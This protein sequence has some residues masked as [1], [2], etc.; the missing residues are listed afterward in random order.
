MAKKALKG[1]KPTAGDDILNGSNKNDVINGKGGDDVITGGAGND[2][3]NGGAGNDVLR[4]GD[5]DDNLIGGTGNDR[6]LG[7]AGDDTIDATSG[8]DTVDGGA[9]DDIVKVKGNFADAVITAVSGGYK[10]VLGGQTTVIKNVEMVKFSDGIVDADDLIPVTQFVLTSSI[11]TVNGSVGNDTIKSDG[12][13]ISALDTIDGGNGR[14]SIVVTDQT[15]NG[16]TLNSDLANVS[17]VEDLSVTVGG[18]DVSAD[19]SGWVG[20]DTVSVNTRDAGWG[21]DVNLT[22]GGNV[23]SITVTGGDE[24]EI[25]DNGATQAL[26]SVTLNK[27]EDY[28]DIESEALKTLNIAASGDN[29]VS[30]WTDTKQALTATITGSKVVDIDANTATS[31]TASVDKSGQYLGIEADLATSVSVTGAG[32][33]TLN[34]DAAAATSVSFTAGDESTIVVT[35]ATAATTLTF[36]GA[37]SIAVAGTIATTVTAIDASANTGGVTTGALGDDVVFT[38]GAGKDSIVLGATN[39]A[40]DMGAG[41]DTVTLTAALGIG[42]S[43]KGGAGTDTLVLTDTVADGA[44]GSATFTTQVTGFENLKLSNALNGALDVSKLGTFG[45]IT[46]AAGGS[47]ALN[48]LGANST[49]H[50]LAGATATFGLAN[51]A[52]VSDAINVSVE[53]ITGSTS[54]LTLTGIETLN[55]K[56]DDTATVASG[57]YQN[58]VNVIDADLKTVV[59]SGDAGLDLNLLGAGAVTSV[60]TSGITK[61]AV[62]V[63]LGAVAPLTAPATSTITI[64]G[65]DTAT[66]VVGTAIVDPQVS[67]NVTTG[68]GDDLII[69]G[70]G[71]DTIKAGDGANTVNSGAGNDNITGGAGIDTVDGGAGNDTIS[72]LGG[73]DVLKGG[74]GNDS[75]DGGA[76]DDIIEGGLGQ[77][78]LTG[79]AGKDTFVFNAA[80]SAFNA[81]DTITDFASGTDKLQLAGVDLADFIF[82][83][84]VSGDL[85]VQAAVADGANVGDDMIR[86][87]FNSANNTLYVDSDSSG[88]IGAGDLVIKLNG[89]TSLSFDAAGPFADDFLFAI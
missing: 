23:T 30:V 69:G 33:L 19:V 53:G 48:G 57:M 31:V 22:T 55:L 3:L 5:G 62:S 14:D 37:G 6:L 87:V 12:F 51:S 61:G 58:V 77:D 65:G 38:G 27:L 13:G 8:N 43:V 85:S 54:T 76:G 46:L 18:G 82:A 81:F 68:K 71:N 78:A 75:I 49:V 17:N 34:V 40:N 45:D 86:A 9:G 42:G 60:D 24:V 47:G 28:A 21:N 4:G 79:G 63:T 44:A 67:L 66:T 50:L 16:I 39:K 26:A 88:T 11:D 15:T 2:T 25:S 20:L 10:I 52:G 56:S 36:A 35:D 80:D 7:G 29:N 1:N 84:N 70:A 59:A 32:K 74:A 83:G 41:D 72:G 89:V 64:N 73:N